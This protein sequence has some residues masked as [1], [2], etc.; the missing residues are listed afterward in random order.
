MI[1]TLKNGRLTVEVSSHGAEL[2]SILYNNRQYL[3]QGNP[4]YWEDRAIVLFP[5]VGRCLNDKIAANGKSYP[6]EAHGF[7]QHSEFALIA[8]SEDSCTLC[9]SST[10]ETRAIYPFDFKL[11]VTYTLSDSQI[12]QKLRV[13]NTGSEPLYFTIGGHPGFCC[14]GESDSFEDWELILK[15]DT[16]LNTT[17]VTED[18]YISKEKKQVHSENGHISLARDLFIGDALIFEETKSNEIT[19]KNKTTAIGVTLDYSDFPV[20]AAWTLPEDGADFVCLEP[21][22]GMGHIEGEGADLTERFGMMCITSGGETT[23]SFTIKIF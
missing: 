10:E 6:M 12:C 3:W 20:I 16:S 1:H 7:A 18:C 17:L 4:E 13:E 9:L 5:V 21:W 23:K 19:L 8:L 22:C 14:G 2:R 11:Y 15:D